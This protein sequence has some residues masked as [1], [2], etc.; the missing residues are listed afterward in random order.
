MAVE[1][2]IGILS[3]LLQQFLVVHGTDE[4]DTRIIVETGLGLEFIKE[5]V[6]D[7]RNQSEI[8]L[9]VALHEL[10]NHCLVIVLRNEPANH[11]IIR[12]RRQSLDLIPVLQLRIVIL[13][14]AALNFGTV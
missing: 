2:P 13:D 12:L 7:V 4:L 14:A 8:P 9:R 1:I 11:Q 5:L 10:A 6:A 3:D